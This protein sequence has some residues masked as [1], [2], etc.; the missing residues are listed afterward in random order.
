MR[1]NDLT[2]MFPEAK[3]CT[4]KAGAERRVAKVREALDANAVTHV[5]VQRDDGVYLPVAILH[6]RNSWLL[7]GLIDAGFCVT[8]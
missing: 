8:N 2:K 5:V 7:R 6:D 3:G 4:T 1:D